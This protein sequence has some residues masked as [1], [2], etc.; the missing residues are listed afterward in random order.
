SGLTQPPVKPGETFV[1]EVTLQQHGTHMYHPHADEMVQMAMGMM[2]MFIIHPKTPTQPAVDRDSAILLHDWAVLP[3]TS[4]PNPTVMREVDLCT[5]NRRV[6]PY[7]VSMVAQTGER[8][9][10]RVGDLSMWTHPM[11][12]QGG[13]FE[14]TGSDGGRWPEHQWRR[15]VTQI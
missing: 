1:Y 12:L 3:G 8:V 15:E 7:L 2:G 9:R 14:V 13:Q 5:M 6:L 11:H 4:R 10:I